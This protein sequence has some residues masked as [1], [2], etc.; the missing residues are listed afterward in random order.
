[1]KTNENGEK[2]IMA[3]EDSPEDYEALLRALKKAGVTNPVVRFE[4]GDDALDYLCGRGG[5]LESVRSPRPAIMLLDLNL[6]GLDGREVL[7]II[8]TDPN[9]RMIPVVILTTSSEES[10]VLGCY[11]EGANSYVQKP[12]RIDDL[13]SVMRDLS[14]FWLDSALLPHWPAGER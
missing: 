4:S 7:H 12:L 14:N 10:D 6:P 11:A 5:H 2:L 8:K 1:M 13:V 9:L 3:V